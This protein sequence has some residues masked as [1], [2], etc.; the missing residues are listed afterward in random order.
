MKS[1]D[2]VASGDRAAS[3][4]VGHALERAFAK[5]GGL[6][7]R[8]GDVAPAAEPAPPA[9][10]VTRVVAV[11]SSLDWWPDALRWLQPGEAL[12]LVSVVAAW[13]A[14]GV[15]VPVP[16]RVLATFWFLL[17]CPGFAVLRV[18]QFRN[19]AILATLSLGGSIGILTV[20][21][22]VMLYTH[23]WSPGAAVGGL[24]GFSLGAL[25]LNRLYQG[26]GAHALS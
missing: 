6:L 23:T 20:L 8:L 10:R 14:I 15:R 7:T 21:S 1:E 9:S 4:D 12:V 17:A 22:E 11:G 16:F 26:P 2:C 25:A 3:E 13:V 19:P 24:A 5:L 18:F